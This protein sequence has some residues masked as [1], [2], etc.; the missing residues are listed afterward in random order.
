MVSS[1][2]IMQNLSMRMKMTNPQTQEEMAIPMKVDFN[3]KIT[4][5]KL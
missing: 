5:T 2:N 3:M 4:V 1:S